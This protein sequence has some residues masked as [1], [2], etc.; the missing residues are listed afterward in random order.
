MHDQLSRNPKKLTTGKTKK[1]F[2]S[3]K[4][5]YTELFRQSITAKD[6]RRSAYY[7]GDLIIV[8]LIIG[9]LTAA[10]KYSTDLVEYAKGASKALAQE[11][12][13]QLYLRIENKVT[14]V[15]DELIQKAEIIVHQ[16][17]VGFGKRG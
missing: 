2:R 11:F 12:C 10:Y 5:N 1:N 16:V 4:R 17:C 8:N 15:P 14:E 6:I 3:S 13:E 9:D 7:V